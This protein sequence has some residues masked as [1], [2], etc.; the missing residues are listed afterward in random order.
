MRTRLSALF[1]GPRDVSCPEEWYKVRDGAETNAR[2]SQKPSG[3]SS[4]VAL[5]QTIRGSGLSASEGEAVRAKMSLKDI[6]KK[7]RAAGFDC[8]W[9]CMG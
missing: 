1:G 9:N 6:F 3:N 8:M 5:S 7:N 2:K 4:N